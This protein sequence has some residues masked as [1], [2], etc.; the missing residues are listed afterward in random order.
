MPLRT[1]IF[2]GI[3]V[4]EQ[5]QY[6]QVGKCGES[7]PFRNRIQVMYLEVALLGHFA[8]RQTAAATVV[9]QR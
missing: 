9:L 7:M 2:V 6:G 4:V 5:A 3:D 1:Q 8:S